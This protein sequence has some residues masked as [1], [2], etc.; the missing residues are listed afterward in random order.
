MELSPLPEVLA[1]YGSHVYVDTLPDNSSPADVK[2]GIDNKKGAVV[3]VQTDAYVACV[4]GLSEG[5][6]NRR[7]IQQI[8]LCIYDKKGRDG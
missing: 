7:R 1:R 3:V 4:V 5:L 8:L 6:W 2:L